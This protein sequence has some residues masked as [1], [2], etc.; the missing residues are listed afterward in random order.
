MCRI[1]LPPGLVPVATPCCK[2]M[3]SPRNSPV[4]R[5]GLQPA[6]S[7]LHPTFG[8]YLA[9]YMLRN[10]AKLLFAFPLVAFVATPKPWLQEIPTSAG[11]QQDWTEIR[12][13]FEVPASKLSTA[14]DSLAKK[15]YLRQTVGDMDF[16]G[17]P[18]FV[19][20]GTTMPYLVRALY[21]NG[22]TGSFSLYWT[23]RGVLVVAHSSL[24]SPRTV[25]RSAL[26]ACLP[27]APSGVSS[28]LPHAM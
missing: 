5:S 23:Q 19:C 11:A 15:A 16:F 4:A 13:F 6:Y 18:G 10:I 8:V 25:L 27:A 12:T 14:E 21:D 7:V 24:G 1:T 22:G 9:L 3:S 17:R 2:I 26:I 28:D 20:P